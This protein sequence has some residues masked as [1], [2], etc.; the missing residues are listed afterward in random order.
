MILGKTNVPQFTLQGYTDNRLFGPTRNPWNLALTPG[1]SS[2]GAVA[3][4]ASG[5]GSL[6]LGTDGGGS[7]RRP[8]AYTGLV[9]FEPSRGM[10]PRGRGFPPVLHDFE[11]VGPIAHDVDDI[12]VAMNAIGGSRWRRPQAD[13]SI[14]PLRILYIPVFD[15]APVDP[16]IA[17]AVA[18]VAEEF[19]NQGH[20]VE[21]AQRF[22]LAAPISEVWPVI[23]QTG[24]AW[25][26]SQHPDAD[27]GQAFT[28][29]AGAGRGYSAIDY[30]GALD[31]VRGI[32][33]EFADLF[34]RFNV[35]LTPAT[36]AMPWPATNPTPR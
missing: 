20:H 24:L 9:G 27:L 3:A 36:A 11:V 8:S 30:A 1:G 15:D 5:M 32:E 25:L 19:A 34:E 22:D 14:A 7:I 29:M 2:G 13:T 16:V 26:L 35:L 18:V 12:I 10:V 31:A 17:S 28:D 33:R 23:S 4:V 6:A 21:R